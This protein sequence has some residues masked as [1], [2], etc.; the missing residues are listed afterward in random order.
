MISELIYRYSTIMI[1]IYNDS[2]N[3]Y[4]NR[5]LNQAI[6]PIGHTIKHQQYEYNKQQ[7]MLNGRK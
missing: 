4:S 6:D 3:N 1:Y 2:A 7:R 5:P